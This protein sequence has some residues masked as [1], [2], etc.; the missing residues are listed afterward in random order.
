MVGFCP[1]DIP[2][3]EGRGFPTDSPMVGLPG[4]HPSRHQCRGF[5]TDS[6][7]VGS[8]PRCAPGCRRPWFPYRLPDGRLRVWECRPPN[9]PWFPYRLPDGRLSS[10]GFPACGAP[11]FPYRLPDGR[12]PS[13]QDTE[14]PLIS[15]CSRRPKSEESQLGRGDFLIFRCF[16]QQQAH[17]AILLVRHL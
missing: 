2:L 17:A 13:R 3:N 9:R 6:P 11:W 12:L 1:C 8:T 16:S 4:R 15:V 5:P 10:S 14:T 7:M